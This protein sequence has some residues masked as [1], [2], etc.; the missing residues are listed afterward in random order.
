MK[1]KSTNFAILN[2]KIEELCQKVEILRNLHV[3]VA[4]A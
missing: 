2:E 4:M 3:V 1:C